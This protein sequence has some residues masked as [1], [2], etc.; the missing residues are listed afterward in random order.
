LRALA[1]ILLANVVDKQ[2]NRYV[3]ASELL[4]RSPSVALTYAAGDGRDL[5]GL[6]P[7][8]LMEFLKYLVRANV[9]VTSK[10]GDVGMK[11]LLEDAAFLTPSW[12]DVEPTEQ[13]EDTPLVEGEVEEPAQRTKKRRGGI[14]SFCENKVSE[15]GRI[16]KHGATK[17]ISQSLDELM[18]GR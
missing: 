4:S 6:R 1:V 7:E 9:P 10:K 15:T 14:W 5:F 3:F 18:L 11:H 12:V 13:D 16:T 8:L 17:P 2:S